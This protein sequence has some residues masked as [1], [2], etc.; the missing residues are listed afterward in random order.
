MKNGAEPVRDITAI[1]K[2]VEST[3]GSGEGLGGRGDF[4]PLGGLPRAQ[5]RPFRTQDGKIG[6][7]APAGS[8][9]PWGVSAP[10]VRGHTIDSVGTSDCREVLGLTH[11]GA[12][13]AAEVPKGDV[14][15]VP[16][17]VGRIR[18]EWGSPGEGWANVNKV[19]PVSVFSATTRAAGRAPPPVVGNMWG[20]H[21]MG[22]QDISEGLGAGVGS[23]EKGKS[24]FVAPVLHALKA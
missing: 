22:T 11:L 20:I 16:Q 17:G 5:H 7:E 23:P 24:V 4:S 8:G 18:E 14:A 10:P 1:G 12:D 19:R 9:P 3:R 6:K 21:R 15:C 2:N 13:G